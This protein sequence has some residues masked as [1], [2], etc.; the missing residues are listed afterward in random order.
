MEYIC[1]DPHGSQSFVT[2][3]ST[4]REASHVRRNGTLFQ[5][6]VDVLVT[7]GPPLGHGD[8]CSNGVRAGCVQ[9]LLTIQRTTSLATYMKVYNQLDLS[10]TGNSLIAG[11]GLTCDGHT[12][13]INCSTCNLTY[14]PVHPPVVFDVL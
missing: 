14:Q 13:F 3:P 8:L 10:V 12:T 4:F 9:L 1:G 6:S 7:H 11:H 2:G 5:D